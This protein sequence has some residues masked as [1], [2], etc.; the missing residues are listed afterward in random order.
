MELGKVFLAIVVLLI[1]I[2]VGAGGGC[3]VGGLFPREWW[4]SYGM[5][6]SNA[7]FLGFLVGTV[8]GLTLGI[9][10][11]ALMLRRREE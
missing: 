4:A 3:L 11:V 6:I 8:V 7:E 10:L 1:S 5:G 2:L 9:T